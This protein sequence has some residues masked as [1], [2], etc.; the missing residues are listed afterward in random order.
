MDSVLEQ[1]LASLE[2]AKMRIFIQA[3]CHVWR[4]FAASYLIKAG[5][6]IV[7]TCHSW[8][9]YYV[10]LPGCFRKV[11]KKHLLSSGKSRS[12]SLTHF[13][14][15]MVFQWQKGKT[16]SCKAACWGARQHGVHVW[17]DRRINIC[18][19]PPRW[20]QSL[21]SLCFSLGISSYLRLFHPLIR[22]VQIFYLQSKMSMP[23]L[24]QYC[25][26]SV[27]VL[28]ILLFY[29]LWHE[30]I[31]SESFLLFSLSVPITA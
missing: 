11:N 19:A 7:N 8:L 1:T 23:L 26:F 10:R 14:K 2:S 31:T 4:G 13:S 25:I 6:Q 30:C 29:V 21:L 20:A 18:W 28:H 15:L 27:I 16:M 22:A 9:D 12:K 17:W 3:R 5:A 24:R